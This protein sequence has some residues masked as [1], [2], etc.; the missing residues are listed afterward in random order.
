MTY[1][2]TAIEQLKAMGARKQYVETAQLIQAVLQLLS[3]FNSYKS[4][5]E[6]SK[7]FE[8]VASIEVDLKKQIF[9]D[10]EAG[11]VKGARRRKMG[12]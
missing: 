8:N 10:F 3:H 1:Q 7:L 2:V 6:V 12:R 4:I 5:R 9:S 11:Y